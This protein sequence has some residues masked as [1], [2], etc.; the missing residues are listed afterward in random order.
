MLSS[1]KQPSFSFLHYPVG[2]E[3]LTK[4]VTNFFFLISLILV[5]LG[6]TLVNHI[7][8]LLVK[9]H[10]FLMH[11][12]CNSKQ[13]HTHTHTQTPHGQKPHNKNLVHF[14]VCKSVWIMAVYFSMNLS[15]LLSILYS[16]WNVWRNTCIGGTCN[17]GFCETGVLSKPNPSDCLAPELPPAIT[18]LRASG[19]KSFALSAKSF[20]FLTSSAFL[21]LCW[22]F[23]L[24]FH[25]PPMTWLL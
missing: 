25:L 16:I 20:V 7:R 21:V 4:L 19:I 9:H 12:P 18:S 6:P 3:F 11:F 1:Q 5:S 8:I 15:I 24:S 2:G 14:S 23:P 22:S 10:F 13:K 17:S